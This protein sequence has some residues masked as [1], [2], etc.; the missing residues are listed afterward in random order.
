MELQSSLA[1]DAFCVKC[2]AGIE[3][4]QQQVALLVQQMVRVI[5]SWMCEEELYTEKSACRKRVGLVKVLLCSVVEH[6]TQLPE[7]P[8]RG[9]QSQS[10]APGL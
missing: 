7:S 8:D 1:P 3:Q 4:Q 2:G 9:G 10:E 5:T 6:R